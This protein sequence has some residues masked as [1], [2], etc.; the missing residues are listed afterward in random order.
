MDSCKKQNKDDGRWEV[1]EDKVNMH[2]QKEMN[3]DDQY[4]KL[5]AMR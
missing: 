2:G 4:I 5:N 3:T 1:K